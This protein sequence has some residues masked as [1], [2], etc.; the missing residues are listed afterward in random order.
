MLG[1]VKQILVNTSMDI[2]DTMMLVEAAQDHVVMVKGKRVLIDGNEV[3]EIHGGRWRHKGRI[4]P[5]SGYYL[6]LINGIDQYRRDA[7]TELPWRAGAYP[8]ANDLV[9][10]INYD[11]SEI[12]AAITS[13]N[14]E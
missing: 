6:K 12:L 11:A 10:Q 7:T 2:R 3:G 14:P 1:F 4:T 13:S 9:Q 5:T 8:Y